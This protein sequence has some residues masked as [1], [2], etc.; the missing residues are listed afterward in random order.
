MKNGR[1]RSRISRRRY[2]SSA[3]L[4]ERIEAERKQNPRFRAAFDDFYELCRQSINP[5]LS[6]QAVEEML[7][8]HVLTERIFRTVFR[9]SDFTRRN[10]I[11]VEIE[12]VV[13]ARTA[14]AFSRLDLG[15]KVRKNP[16]LSGTTH[17][18]FGIQV[19]VSTNIFV[20]KRRR[21]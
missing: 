17:N 2:L 1:R 19:G 21:A 9:N 4:K 20:R 8:Q 3:A 18:V 6:E 12:R 10:V 11:A 13:D 14:R 5:N 16:K 7:I 15:G